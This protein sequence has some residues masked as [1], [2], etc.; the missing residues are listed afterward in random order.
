[1]FY[2]SSLCKK[3]DK[4]KY[5]NSPVAPREKG[6]TGKVELASIIRHAA[7]TRWRHK[8]LPVCL[9]ENRSEGLGILSLN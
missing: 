3:C 5:G 7:H 9:G 2:F 4:S 1:M 6:K 8:L